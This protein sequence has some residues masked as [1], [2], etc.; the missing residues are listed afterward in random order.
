MITS[1]AE[2][3]KYPQDLLTIDNVVTTPIRIPEDEPIY[4]IDLN[5]R[6]I[7][8][9]EFLS[10]KTDHQAE[11]IYFQVDRYFENMD[12]AN[13]VC[14]VEY[15][16]ENATDTWGEPVGMGVYCVPVVDVTTLK[17]ENKMIIPWVITGQATAAAGNVQ[18]AV[19]FFKFDSNIE[20]G[21]DP[22]LVYSLSTQIANSKVLYGMDSWSPE[23]TSNLVVPE[24][25]LQSIWGIVN[26]MKENANINWIEATDLI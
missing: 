26:T 24:D 5:S 11:I 14:I 7:D 15:I 12:L 2:Y 23:N 13:T 8:A 18:F 25:Y 10:V 6:I 16:N 20:Q 4:N 9:P 19:R 22:I 1:P 17:E 3:S 21:K